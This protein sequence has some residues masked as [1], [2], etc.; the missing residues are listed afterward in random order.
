MKFIYFLTHLF[1]RSMEITMHDTERQKDLC[2]PGTESSVKGPVQHYTNAG[3]SQPQSRV[4]CK[5]LL[6]NICHLWRMTICYTQSGGLK[7]P[8]KFLIYQET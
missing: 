4:S 2:S 5:A 8:K 1:N 6:L 7:S 3:E